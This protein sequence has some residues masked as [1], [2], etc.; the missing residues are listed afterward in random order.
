MQS[1]KLLILPNAFVDTQ[2]LDELMPLDHLKK[3]ASSV[4]AWVFESK[5]MGFRF[6]AKLKI[7][8]LKTL[9]YFELS[10]HTD[11]KALKEIEQELLSGKT[12]GL[13]S[14]AGLPCLADPGSKLVLFCR[15]H[16]IKVE[17]VV[18][19]SSITLALLLSGLSAQ[20]FH[21]CGYLPKDTVEKEAKV[22][23]LIDRSLK[24]EMTV[25]C[26]E[27]PYRNEALL[28]TLVKLLPKNAYLSLAIDLT[29]PNEEVI[30]QRPQEIKKEALKINDRPMI[31]L[32][33]FK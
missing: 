19:P 30:T 14:D 9:P 7:P 10:E 33:G 11:E 2:P 12:L 4:S 17:Y 20:N 29:L 23:M 21:F 27:T 13:V 22:K 5:K 16:R 28:D 15:K 18:G 8:E 24:E 6:V 25:A 31:F 3:M 26:I 32:F 1:G